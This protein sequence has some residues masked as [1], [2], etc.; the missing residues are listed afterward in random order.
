MTPRQKITAT[1][2]TLKAAKADDA[3]TLDGRDS[4]QL[5]QSAHVARTDNPHS[6]TAAQIGAITNE[7]DP[8]VLASV[9]DGVS[10]SELS[11]IP[12]GFDD[13]VDNTGIT[14]ETDPQVGINSFNYVP[15]WNGSELVSGDIYNA[16]GKV[17]I[18]TN[19][20]VYGKL[21]VYTSEDNNA[22]YSISTG[23]GSGLYAVST[24]TD[25]GLHG[26]VGITYNSNQAGVYGE[27]Y[28]AG[29]GVIADG[30]YD[31]VAVEL[32]DG[33]IK[34]PDGTVQTTAPAPTWHQE[35]FLQLRSGLSW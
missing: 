24:D 21:H 17:G 22:I 11:G 32:K 10:W 26:V 2:F 34:F 12:A 23:A 19:N 7:T 20:P 18:G 13:G 5:D 28:G 16:V 15:K 27:N 33:G 4:T 6:V 29:P 30:G 3:D 31:G 14:A 9:K 8:T 25:N 1:A 35:I